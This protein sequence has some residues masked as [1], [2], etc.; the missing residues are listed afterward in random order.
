[1]NIESIEKN[2]KEIPTENLL[3]LLELIKKELKLR[4]TWVN[5]KGRVKYIKSIDPKK[6]S[7][8]IEANK[9]IDAH[10]SKLVSLININGIPSHRYRYYIPLIKQ[11]WST[12]YKSGDDTGEYYVYAHVNPEE[13]VFVTKKKY[14]GNFKGTPFYIGKGKH[15]R[16]YDLNRN[17]GHGKMIKALIKSGWDKD[18]LVTIL[19]KDLNEQKAYEIESKLIYFFGTIYEKDRENGVLYNLDIPKKPNF[20]G[21]MQK[22]ITR[23]SFSV[24]R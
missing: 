20:M 7:S 11:D 12:V 23:E 9:V 4:R 16:A 19:F 5:K 21:S 18:S 6:Y 15:D 2:F 14:G 17:Q 3:D 22:L 24:K 10:N 8:N 1:M 13:K